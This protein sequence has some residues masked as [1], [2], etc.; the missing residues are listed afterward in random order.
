MPVDKVEILRYDMMSTTF[1]SNKMPTYLLGIAII[2]LVHIFSR[3][4]VTN[5]V[6]V[7]ARQQ[8]MANLGFAYGISINIGSYMSNFTKVHQNLPKIDIVVIPN[9]SVKS[10]GR[11]GLI[12]YG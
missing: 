11:Y 5:T 4:L 8:D 1:I 3:D 9:S 12:F 10:H 6:N 2:D 7:W